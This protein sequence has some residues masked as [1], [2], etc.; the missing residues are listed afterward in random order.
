M[1]DSLLESRPF[2]NQTSRI[3][4]FPYY[5]QVIKSQ[6]PENKARKHILILIIELIYSNSIYLYA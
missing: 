5:L 2:S 1:I 4:Q 6:M 3:K